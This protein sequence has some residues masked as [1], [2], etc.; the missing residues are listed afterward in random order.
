M[1]HKIA[2]VDRILADFNNQYSREQSAPTNL[3][4]ISH[5]IGA[6]LVQCLLLERPDILARTQHVIHLMPF[7][8]FDPPF[9]K[10]L[11]LS[12]VAKHHNIAIPVMTTAVRFASYTLPHKFVDICMKY[13]AGVECDKGRQIALD[14]FGS[15]NM[16]RNHLILGTQE[17]RGEPNPRMRHLIFTLAILKAEY[18]SLLTFRTSRDTKCE[19]ITSISIIYNVIV[20]S[21]F[22]FLFLPFQ[23]IALRLI[24]EVCST[25]ILFCDPD[26]WAPLFHMEDL[27]RLQSSLTIPRNI[28]T[29]YLDGLSH[30]FV[31]HPEMLQPVVQFCIRCIE[32][33]V[34]NGNGLRDASK[35]I[36]KL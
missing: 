25:S 10:K 28:E 15:P 14:I 4:F 3:I 16:V 13:I 23:D 18:L 19:Y 33:R 1:E 34:S 31:V 27:Q 20:Q 6:H 26:Q 17:V 9:M 32:Q 5:S 12:T 2:W 29:Q 22:Y 30:D 24:G 8:R 7:F 36:S 21:T 11:M 35:I